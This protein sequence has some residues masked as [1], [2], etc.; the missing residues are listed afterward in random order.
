MFAIRIDGLP[1]TVFDFAA[2]FDLDEFLWNLFNIA[3]K[4]FEN[5][6]QCLVFQKKK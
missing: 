3:L 5:N 1:L 4:N 2:N 6:T